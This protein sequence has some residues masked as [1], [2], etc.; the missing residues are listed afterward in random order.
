MLGKRPTRVY[1]LK[2]AE[3]PQ[4]ILKKETSLD[5]HS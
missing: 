2:T 3:P 4:K 5:Q 1:S